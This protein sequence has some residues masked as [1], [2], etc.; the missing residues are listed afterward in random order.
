MTR[1][2]FLYVFDEL[3]SFCIFI[4]DDKIQLCLNSSANNNNR[5]SE[6]VWKKAEHQDKVEGHHRMM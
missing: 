5:E 2:P 1:W 3:V 6:M 4:Y